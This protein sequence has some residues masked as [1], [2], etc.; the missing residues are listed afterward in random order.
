MKVSCNLNI[1]HWLPII[2]LFVIC[3]LLM[4]KK[5]KQTSSKFYILF[6]SCLCKGLS[7]I[8]FQISFDSSEVRK[9]EDF[10]SNFVERKKK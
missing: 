2:V 4:E 3:L 1:L 10:L 9:P 7:F 5:V 8:I 6:L